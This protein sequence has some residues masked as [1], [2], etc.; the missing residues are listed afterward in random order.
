MMQVQEEGW[1]EA[2]QEHCTHVGP[3]EELLESTQYEE[4]VFAE[5]SAPIFAHPEVL[6]V[7]SRA[8]CG[9]FITIVSGDNCVHS[10]YR[11]VLHGMLCSYAVQPF[12]RPAFELSAPMRVC[13]GCKGRACSCPELYCTKRFRF[14]Y[15]L[16]GNGAVR[17]LEHVTVTM[18]YTIESV[19]D[20]PL[21]ANYS[22]VHDE[23]RGLTA[24]FIAAPALCPKSN[25]RRL[26]YRMAHHTVD[27]IDGPL[28]VCH[29]R[30]SGA[31][32]PKFMAANV[33]AIVKNNNEWFNANPL[34]RDAIYAIA[35]GASS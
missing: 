19:Y 28:H 3:L 12:C 13:E 21:V 33:R 6:E 10:K 23:A 31:T 14:E 8:P 29:A 22:E 16:D 26:A 5:G 32:Q 2:V 35:P 20:K 17:D 15:E 4:E 24:F 30:K 34:L 1:P 9:C 25:G 7:G 27:T 11:M 18:Q